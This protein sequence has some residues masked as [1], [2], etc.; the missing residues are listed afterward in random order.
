MDNG[1]DDEPAVQA[2]IREYEEPLTNRT[3]IAGAWRMDNELP[4][5]PHETLFLH[6][7][8]LSSEPSADQ[9]RDSIPYLP[10]ASQ[11]GGL[12]DAGVPFCLPG[13]QN[14]DEA[15]AMN[16]TSDPLDDAHYIFGNPTITLYI[17]ADV[18]VIPV[19]VRLTEIGPDGTGILLS[20]GLLNATR[21]NG[22]DR[23]DPLT[24]GEITK[25]EFHLEATSWKFTMGNRYRISISGSDFPNI[26][27]TPYKGNITLHWGPDAPS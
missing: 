4:D 9:G 18:P 22:M 10:A 27:P 25:L 24:P 14:L 23:A 20:R 11:N 6:S 17:S 8:K 15:F 5:S 7:S 13:P 16:F 19:A 12:W 1:V 26:W 2:Y 21:R 3:T